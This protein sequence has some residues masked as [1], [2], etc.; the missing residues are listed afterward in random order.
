MAEQ[1]ALRLRDVATRLC[2]SVDT[3]RR[4]IASGQLVAI[5]VSVTRRSKKPR[6][7]VRPA[8]LAAFEEGRENQKPVVR[9]RPRAGSYEDDM[10]AL[11]AHGVRC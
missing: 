6:H 9:A 1:N 5:N 2:V 3:V 7:V 10:A 4:W 11:R 8:D